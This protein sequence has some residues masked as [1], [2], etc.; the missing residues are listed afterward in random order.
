[1]SGKLKILVWIIVAL[2]VVVAA[3]FGM[4]MVLGS[5]KD[6][7]VYDFRI[8]QTGANN[9]S[10]ELV[11]K[12]VYLENNEANFFEF[13][14]QINSTDFGVDIYFESSDASVAKAY[15]K[16]GRYICRYYRAGTATITAY[17]GESLQVY[18]SF[19]VNV[20]ENIIDTLKFS[21]DKGFVDKNNSLN[22][23]IYDDGKEYVYD[24]EAIGFNNGPIN[25]DSISLE[26]LNKE[27]KLTSA[28]LDTENQQLK[29][30]VDNIGATNIKTYNE[31]L[32]LRVSYK[33]AN[34]NVVAKYIT[35]NVSI[36]KNESVGYI[37][38]ISNSPYFDAEQYF[39][40]GDISFDDYSLNGEE[41][42]VSILLNK[43]NKDF[44][45]RFYQLNTNKERKAVTLFNVPENNG[46]LKMTYNDE[47][48]FYKFEVESATAFNETEIAIGEYVTFKITYFAEEEPTSYVGGI[49][50]NQLLYIYIESGDYYVYTYWDTRFINLNA[51]YD[52]DGN[53]IG[54]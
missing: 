8:M 36:R 30:K 47:G 34:G 43:N 20:R 4:T 32:Y 27:S 26:D 19:T 16:D 41:E 33:S 50:N 44:Y 13:K 42:V 23:I 53:I 9:V 49:P 6:I 14:L 17:V 1:M 7:L 5:S 25:H 21:N 52:K 2:V 46:A 11:D 40:F 51:K 45:V 3:V 24:Y 39:Y 54:F 35:V 48:Q 28:V 12:T 31:L 37:A 15:R 22:L 18:D 10:S 29:L 38:A